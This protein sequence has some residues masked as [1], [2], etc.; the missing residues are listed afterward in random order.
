[1]LFCFG[2]LFVIGYD[3][4]CLVLLIGFVC[5]LYSFGCGCGYVVV[6]WFACCWVLVFVSFV[7]FG[8]D[9]DCW[10]GG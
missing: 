6:W 2:V 3:V 1:M 9:G 8:C 10:F 4:F 5:L 7:V